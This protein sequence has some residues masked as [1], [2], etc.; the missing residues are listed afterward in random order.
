[1]RISKERKN[2]LQLMGCITVYSFIEVWRKIWHSNIKYLVTV[3]VFLTQKVVNSL[4]E[5]FRQF[6]CNG[7]ALACCRAHVD[8]C[9]GSGIRLTL[10]EVGTEVKIL[11]LPAWSAMRAS[12]KTC[13]AI[14]VVRRH[15]VSVPGPSEPCALGRLWPPLPY[16]VH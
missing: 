10:P 6:S 2:Y 3:L 4:G 14:G 1:M 12:A 8:E 15:R 9:S 13:D 16:L 5:L 7:R 11:V